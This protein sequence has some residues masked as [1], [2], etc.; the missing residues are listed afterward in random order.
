MTL[1]QAPARNVSVRVETVDGTATSPGPTTRPRR[2]PCVHADRRAHEPVT[3][4]VRG[5]L[6][7]EAD[8]TFSVRVVEPVPTG[9][10]RRRLGHVTIVNDDECTVVGTTGTDNLTG[11]PGDD[12]ICGLRPVTTSSTAAAATTRSGATAA[13]TR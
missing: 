3:I 4:A 2:R 6:L 11:T 13:S 1:S 7:A 9:R 8:E 12:V 5:D 10:H